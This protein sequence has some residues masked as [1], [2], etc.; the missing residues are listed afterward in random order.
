MQKIIRL[1]L[2]GL[3]SF[4]L[5]TAVLTTVWAPGVVKRTPIDVNSKT[6]LLGEAQRLDAETG[7]LGAASDIRAVRI[8]QADSKKSDDDVAVFVSGS[9][10]VVNEDGNAP[11]CVDGEDPRLVT[12][13]EST[14]ATD[15]V[16]GLAVDN[17][18]YL[19]DAPVQFEGL[20]NKWPFDAEKK[21]YPYWDAT[22][23]EPVDAVFEGTETIEGVDTYR[24]KANVDEAPIEVA[25]GVDGTYT[26]E[27]IVWIEP[28]TGSIQN[29]SQDQQRY[30]ANGTQVLNLQAKFSPEQLKEDAADTKDSMRQLTLVTRTVPIV[31]FVAG[32]L[33][34]LAALAL[35]LRARSSSQPSGRRRREKTITAV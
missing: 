7:E 18:D 32:T 4:L 24:Y 28:K 16:T 13:S 23:G 29:Q 11:D 33:C 27:V 20:V 25:E 26:S 19:P 5:V 3:G 12:A 34:L 8:T 22:L 21:T 2:L 35:F 30:L 1:V 9:C 6:V 10:V 31:G 15:R 17:G 14:F